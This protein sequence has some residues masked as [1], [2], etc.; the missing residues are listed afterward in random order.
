MISLL[1][2]LLGGST[3]AAWL[4]VAALGAGVVS[5][6][7]WYASNQGYQR[8]TLEWLVRYNEREL[9]LERQRLAELDRQALANDQAKAAER[10]ALSQLRNEMAQ[11]EIQL[12]ERANEAAED[13][14]RGNIACNLECV[15]RHNSVAAN[16]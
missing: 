8:A 4:V 5:G 12:Q 9:A 7:Y 6:A 14:D 16:K 11:L 13:P 1:A 15:R 3:I 2:R 10:A